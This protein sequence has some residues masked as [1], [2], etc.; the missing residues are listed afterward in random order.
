MAA[1]HPF[2]RLLEALKSQGCVVRPCGLDKA[3]AQCPGHRDVRPSLGVTRAGDRVLL[4]CFAGCKTPDIV[5]ALGLRMSDLFVPAGSAP[6]K[7]ARIVAT[8][9]YCDLRGEPVA[10]KVRHD[11]KAFRW[12]RPHPS[13][14]NSWL[15]S[16]DGIQPGLYRL[17]ELV[18]VPQVYCLEGEKAV[19]LFWAL[20]LPACCPPSGAS[21][22][23][24]EWSSD[25]RRTGCTELV[26]LPDADH[27]G[28]EHAER[29]AT[30]W[31]E[32]PVNENLEPTIAK[33]VALP[34]L[35]D[36]ADACDWLKA[37]HTALELEK[38]VSEASYWAPGAIGRARRERRRALTRDR[39]RRHR[40]R[41]RVCNA[42]NVRDGVTLVTR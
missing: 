37:G 9:N 6:K 16:L 18:D 13:K 1:N 2:E 30:S 21:R 22:W 38:I 26:I 32:Q 40:A 3:R 5:R 12:R 10:Q 8:Y 14:P 17:H 24:P 29:V 34:G 28:T 20:G 35:T 23:I 36:G 11:P 27:A 7:S 41:H 33:V 4:N 31:F 39:V 15:S 42:V 19:D 25:L